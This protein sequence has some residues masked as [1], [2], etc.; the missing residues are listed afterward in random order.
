LRSP[1]QHSGAAEP[2]GAICEPPARGFSKN[3]DLSTIVVA[4]GGRPLRAY[5]SSTTAHLDSARQI[6]QVRTR[7]VSYAQVANILVWT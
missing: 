6:V 4:R 1:I 7:S 5:R 2:A 3:A